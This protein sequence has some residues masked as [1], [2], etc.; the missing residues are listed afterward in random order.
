MSPTDQST[1]SETGDLPAVAYIR[2][3][4]PSPADQSAAVHRQRDA[5]TRAA[6][7]LGLTVTEE[8][9]DLSYSGMTLDRPGLRGLLD[10]AATGHVGYCI[11]TQLD[12][13]SRNPEH[14]ADID[15]ALSDAGVAIVDASRRP[16]E[17]TTR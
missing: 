12:R 11:V 3:A 14:Y 4:S 1:P 13:F 2:V 10:R 7:L 6:D 17:E 5:I 8:F 15:Q 9:I 16:G